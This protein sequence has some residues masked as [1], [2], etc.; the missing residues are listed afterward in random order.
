[1]KI[2]T[3]YDYVY[4]RIYAWQLSWFGKEEIPEYTAV[5]GVSFLVYLNV[6]T[7]LIVASLIT[8][9]DLIANLGID[10]PTIFLALLFWVGLNYY[11]FIQSKRREKVVSRFANQTKRKKMLGTFGVLLYAGFSLALPILLP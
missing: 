7:F 4:Y 2:M 9:S 8:G 5:L 11:L 1:M 10:K 6:Y 3:F